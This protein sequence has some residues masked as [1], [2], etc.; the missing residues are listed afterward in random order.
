MDKD[1]I[2]SILDTLYQLHDDMEGE[3][4]FIHDPEARRECVVAIRDKELYDEV[5]KRFS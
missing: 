3:I 1:E 4:F 5:V 2:Q